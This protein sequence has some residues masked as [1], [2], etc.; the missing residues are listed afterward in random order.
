MDAHCILER[1]RT[2]RMTEKQWMVDNSWSM[3]CMVAQLDLQDLARLSLISARFVVE[4]Q[5]CS[6]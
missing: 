6:T 5:A 3:L 1:A 2:V 4:R